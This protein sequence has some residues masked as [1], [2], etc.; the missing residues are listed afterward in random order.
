[1][2]LKKLLIF[3]SIALLS[4]SCKQKPT[5]AERYI[6]V[7]IEP[8]RYFAEKIV[9]DKFKIVTL[10]PAGSSPE[11]FDPTPSQIVDMSKCEAYFPIG[12]FPLEKTW[13]DNV[14][15][16]N[17]K[18]LILDCSTGMDTVKPGNTSNKEHAH[19][20]T[21]PHIWTSPK[22][23]KI[24]SQ[25]ILNGVIKLDSANKSV[26]EKNFENLTR[27]INETDSIVC[28]ILKSAK[29]RTF[30]IYHPALSYFADYYGL[31]QFSLQFEGKNPTPAQLAS[32]VTLAK[33]NGIKTIFVQP[34]F[35]K[36]NA[37]T[38]SREIGGNIV[39]I[40]PLAYDWRNEMIKIAKSIAGNE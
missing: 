13:A 23:A 6:S 37:E 1:M 38:L 10:I 3:L 14:S 15:K 40:N 12:L 26:Y 5:N 25:N 30:I 2:Q 16:S 22:E 20:G 32:L 27:E 11:S 35:D 9:G 24:I 31:K 28:S 36:K 19:E 21:D 17:G 4:Y 34:E 18:I 7:T 39:E 29:N 33:T 8:E